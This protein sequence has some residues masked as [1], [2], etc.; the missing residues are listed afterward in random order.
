ML[1]FLKKI[2]WFLLVSSVST[3]VINV[4]RLVLSRI[5]FVGLCFDVCFGDVFRSLFFSFCNCRVYCF[6]S[7]IKGT[8]QMTH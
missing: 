1:D 2:S 4:V 8:S 7:Y 6:I 3:V 5:A